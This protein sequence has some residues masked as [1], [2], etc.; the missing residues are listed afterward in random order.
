METVPARAR[1]AHGDAPVTPP[2]LVAILTDG[3]GL[4]YGKDEYGR[5]FREL[6]DG[7]ALHV[8]RRMFNSLLTLSPSL[9][10]WSWT[11]GW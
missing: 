7:R 11:E 10:S 1:G 5:L 9:N 3:E 2:E 6:A 8:T 4:R